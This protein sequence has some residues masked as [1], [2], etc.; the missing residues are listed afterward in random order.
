MGARRAGGGRGLIRTLGAEAHGNM[1]GGEVYDGGGNE[2]RR[3]LARSALDQ[4]VMFAL[5][6]VESAD[7]RA[8][9]YAD[10]L[11]IFGRDLKLRHFH[12]FIRSGNRKVDEAAH[13]L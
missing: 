4:R 1:A 8:N 2:E 7:A 10:V 13:L 5:D 9:V 6:Y 11:G 12:C 3:D